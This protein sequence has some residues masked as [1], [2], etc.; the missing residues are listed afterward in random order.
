MSLFNL[1]IDAAAK[2]AAPARQSTEADEK[3][4]PLAALAL[5][6]PAETVA[7][8]VTVATALLNA[9]VGKEHDAALAWYLFCLVLT[10][11]F[12]WTGF[13]TQWRK[14][15]GGAYP[16]LADAPWFRIVAS[17]VA[18]A[19]WGLAVAPKVGSEIMCGAVTC[20]ADAVTGAV[21]II[22][23][24][25]LTALDGLIQYKQKPMA[26]AA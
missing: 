13:A 7:I 12:T 20:G 18:F 10:P 6:V 17:A 26:P 25:I 24:V 15:H 23:G 16:A 9:F 5:F 21:V 22:V 3:D 4:N 19:A 14:D 1:G 8:F 2:K 11:I